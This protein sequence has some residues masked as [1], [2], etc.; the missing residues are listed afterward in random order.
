MLSLMNELSSLL[1]SA[2]PH[3]QSYKK[4]AWMSEVQ[5]SCFSLRVVIFLMF[6]PSVTLFL[7]IHI[8]LLFHCYSN[9]PSSLTHS[10]CFPVSNYILLLRW[11]FIHDLCSNFF[12][13]FVFSFPYPGS[14]FPD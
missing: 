14:P 2:V 12:V 8:F 13:N 10:W 11:I 7:M 6:S 5:F 9:F 3:H 1:G 4:S